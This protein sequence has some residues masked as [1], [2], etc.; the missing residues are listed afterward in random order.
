VVLSHPGRDIFLQEALET[1]RPY[2]PCESLDSEDPLFLLYTSGSTGRPKGMV[3]TQAG[4]LL[5]AA[6]THK[7]VFDYHDGDIF[8]CVADVGWITGHS[9]VVYGPLA[10]GAT[11]FMFEAVP[12]HPNEGRYWDCIQRHKITQFYTA[13]TAIRALMRFG[14]EAVKKYDRSSLRILGSVGEPINPEAWK[15][16][17][18]VVGEGRCAIVDTY[19]QTESGAHLITPLPGAT[20]TKPGSASFPFFGIQPTLL[21]AETGQELQGNNVTGVLVISK[22]WP[23]IART[24]YGDHARY[25]STYTVHW[26]FSPSFLTLFLV[27][28]FSFSPP[29]FLFFYSLPESLQWCLFHRRSCQS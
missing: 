26:K 11:T 4:Y 7:Y 21:N 27:L 10:N 16:Y 20:E 8:A 9:Y 3:H 25:L 29:S 5:M 1:Q 18:E 14:E 6:L 28:L 13:P 2:C 23:A 22:P 24:V 15:W 12:T 17:S 19:W